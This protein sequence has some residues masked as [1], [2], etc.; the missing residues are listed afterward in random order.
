MA[1]LAD[2]AALAGVSITTVSRV[3]NNYGAIS[4]KT[5]TKVQSAMKELNYQ[6]NSLARSLQGKRTKLIGLIFPGVSNPFFGDLVQC[7][8]NQ[9]FD[10]GYRVILCNS[11]NNAEKEA[12]YVRML[13][14]NQVDG[15]ISGTHNLTIKEYEAIA[16]PVIAFDRHLGTTI[17]IVSSDNFEGG[18]LA[19]NALV[20]TGA[21]N[22]WIVTG[23]NRPLS[24]T[25]ERLRG[26]Q[27]VMRQSA[28]TPHVLELPFSMSA[29]LK[30][31]RL[32]Q[33]IQTQRPEA[34]FATDDLTA[35]MIEEIARTKKWPSPV[36]SNSLATMGRRQ[37]ERPTPGSPRLF[38][39]SPPSVS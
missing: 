25:N 39:R 8:E 36:N 37:S 22:I 27:A 35:L 10:Q 9:L 23:A 2:V 21:R 28:L 14:A 15:I 26:Y 17:P 6:P 7:L 13:L 5:R 32:Q 30:W 31:V 20:K 19:T 33:L 12:A 16:A 1:K 4:A 18:R 24:P 11:A 3:I 34:V 29:Q 38:S